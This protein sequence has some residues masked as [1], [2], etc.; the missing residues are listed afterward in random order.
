LLSEL[1]ELQAARMLSEAASRNGRKV[2]A[3]VFA[4]RD[5]AYIKLLAQKMTRLEPCVALL[6]T[7]SGQPA[8]V[9]AQSSGEPFDMGALMKEALAE[10][11]GRGGGSKDMAQGG[12]ERV[13]PMAAVLGQLQQRVIQQRS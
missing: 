3:Q 12:P 10:T 1:A 7:T 8:L 4:D 9:F 2:V 11:G 13:Q 6:A 5:L